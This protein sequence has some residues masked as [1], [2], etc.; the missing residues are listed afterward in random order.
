MFTIRSKIT[1]IEYVPK[2]CVYIKN[3]L[4]AALYLKH[5]P[6]I[7]ITVGQDNKMCFV[8]DMEESRDLYRK[9]NSHEL[10]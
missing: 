8:F 10:N 3:P 5:I 9:W 1:G 6:I 4:Q 7:D 2:E